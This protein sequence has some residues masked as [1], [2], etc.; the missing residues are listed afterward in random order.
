VRAEALAMFLRSGFDYVSIADA[1]NVSKL[2][3]FNYFPAK[4]D[5]VMHHV[6]NHADGPV[7]AIRERPDGQAGSPRWS[8]SSSRRWSST[9]GRGW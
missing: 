2:T 4:E 3:A 7:E 9:V 6:E 8:T 1:A 5:L